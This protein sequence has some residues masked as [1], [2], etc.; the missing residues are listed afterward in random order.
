[1]KYLTLL[2]LLAG[3]LTFADTPVPFGLFVQLS[4]GEENPSQETPTDASTRSNL[5]EA[6]AVLRERE[7]AL[8][9]YHPSLAALMVEVAAIASASGDLARAAEFYDRAL[10]NARVK[11][12]L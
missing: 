11:N 12:G 2:L 9:P 3:S 7:R 6:E 4:D 5:A 8:G 10:H 1:M